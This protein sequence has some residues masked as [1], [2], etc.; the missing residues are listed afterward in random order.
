MRCRTVGYPAPASQRYRGRF[1]G[2]SS[3]RALGRWQVFCYPFV[4]REL[5]RSVSSGR[6]LANTA[7]QGTLRDK[8]AQRP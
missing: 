2:A 1:L 3:P 5:G 8:A 7:F 4:I 6:C